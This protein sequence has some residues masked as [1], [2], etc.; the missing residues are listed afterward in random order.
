MIKLTPLAVSKIKEISEAEGI[1]HYSIR[2]SVKGGGCAGMI[3]DM[4]FD[5]L[6]KDTDEIYVFDIIKIIVDQISLQYL[7]DIIIDY[8]DAPFNSG[9]KFNNPNAISSCGCGK[10]QSF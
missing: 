8:I 6:S 10:S 7:E 1:G 4:E 3:T 2:I 5:P 9:F